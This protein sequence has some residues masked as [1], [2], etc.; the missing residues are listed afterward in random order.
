MKKEDLLLIDAWRH[1]EI[2]DE[3]FKLLESRLEKDPELRASFRAL[4]DLEEGLSSIEG[5]V[6]DAEWGHLLWLNPKCG[7]QPSTDEKHA[8]SGALQYKKILTSKD[9]Y[10]SPVQDL[11]KASAA[12]RKRLNSVAKNIPGCRSKLQDHRRNLENYKY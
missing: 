2:S 3:D 11:V 7:R 12:N 10:S 1:G 8:V 4:S 9:W 6:G 5:Q